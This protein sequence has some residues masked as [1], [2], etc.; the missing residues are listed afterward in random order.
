MTLVAEAP[1]WSLQSF[2]RELAVNEIAV[3]SGGKACWAD[4]AIEVE[5]GAA[6][7][8]RTLR[9]RVAFSSTIDD[10]TTL[11]FELEQAG[12]ATRRKVTSH[13]LHG[14]HPFK[15]KF[16]PQLARSLINVAGVEPGMTVLDPFAG[17][18]TT[19][20]EAGLLGVRAVGVDA[21]P[22]AVL[23]SQTKLELLAFPVQTL[24]KEFKSLL[25]KPR[26]LRQHT[27][28]VYLR[29]WFPEKNYMTLMALL[30]SIDR[31]P[32][33]ICR[34]AARVVLSST[35]RRASY[36][37]PDQV[38]VY[39]R[40]AAS[41]IA[42]LGDLFTIA[43]R[44]LMTELE[45][46]QRVPGLSM[47]SFKRHRCRVITGDARQLEPLVRARRGRQF[48]AVVTSPPYANALPYL[49]TDRLSLRA[50]GLLTEP[51]RQ[52]E[53]RLIGNREVT[54]GLQRELEQELEDADWVPRPLRDVLTQTSAVA[55][56]DTAGFRK[57]RTPA[58]LYR[59]FRDMQ[60]VL[61][62]LAAVTAPGAPVIVVVGNNSVSGPGGSVVE[63]P[64]S[65]LLSQL[66]EQAGLKPERRLEKRLTSFGAKETVHQRNAM[67][68]ETILFFRRA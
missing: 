49:D 23:V 37:Q 18:G 36:Q 15:G 9:R 39:R 44:R 10:K 57:R 24:R 62:Q 58:L 54:T 34:N 48:D 52:A 64:T 68:R 46:V 51:Q 12:G 45:A 33:G 7:A 17:C 59:Y 14:L 60:R 40:P 50:L 28:E 8:A 66:G 35:L 20:L 22:L 29:S 3:L 4:G 47:S 21:N 5:G 31:L 1:T 16:Y 53:D 42:D 26:T 19:V 56:E 6:G 43:A 27:D 2:E 11:Q 25:L 41:E 32:T 55:A 13:A 63:I 38:R 30:A 65:D 61:E 67:K